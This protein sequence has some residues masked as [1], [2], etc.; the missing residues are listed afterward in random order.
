MYVMEKY[1][2]FEAGVFCLLF[3]YVIELPFE[4]NTVY[5]SGFSSVRNTTFVQN[6]PIQVNGR[7]TLFLGRKPSMLEAGGS[8][9]LFLCEN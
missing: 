1:D 3:P 4:G 7:S 9:T 8:S 2:V 5:L 6:S